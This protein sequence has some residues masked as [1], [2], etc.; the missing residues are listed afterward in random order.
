MIKI[1]LLL[2]IISYI[3]NRLLIIFYALKIAMIIF[4]LL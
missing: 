1:K 2:G 4:N 3:F